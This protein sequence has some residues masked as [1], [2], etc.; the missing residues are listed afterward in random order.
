MQTDLRASAWV[1][2]QLHSLLPG[3]PCHTSLLPALAPSLSFSPC[4]FLAYPQNTDWG[5]DGYI[6]LEYGDNECG[7]AKEAT[8]VFINK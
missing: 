8:S 3:S 1:P 2:S 6:Y 5:I 4:Y 7:V